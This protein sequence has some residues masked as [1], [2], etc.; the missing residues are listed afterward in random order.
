M[1]DELVAHFLSMFGN[2]MPGIIGNVV[3]SRP[4]NPVDAMEA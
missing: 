2:Q 1:G 4:K 3:K